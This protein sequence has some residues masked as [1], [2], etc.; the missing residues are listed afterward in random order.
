V[1]AAVEVQGAVKSF[2]LVRAVDGVDLRVFRGEIY[3]LVGPSG[4]GKTTLI[5]M[6]C[7]LLGRDAG[8]V[9]VLGHPIPEGKRHV[10]GRLGYMP[11]E[12]A[13][14]RDL[15]VEENLLFFGQ[16]NGM[17]RGEIRDRIAEILEFMRLSHLAVHLAGNLSGGEKQ[18]LSLAC[19]L[20]S[21]PEL[22]VLD[23]P[24]VGL[25]PALRQEFWEH[26]HELKDEGHTI[27]L[28][29]HYLE[30][31]GRCSR[32]GFMRAGRLQV[33]GL[34]AELQ[35]RVAQAV[36]GTPSMEEVFL[37]FARKGVE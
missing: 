8:E 21:K 26:F 30:E 28:T 10:E 20:L 32:V 2:G 34:P 17:P 29:T 18:R 15:T 13:L 16:L 36:G 27:L 9:R 24:T 12:R 19:A 1:E 23:E 35:A 3:G 25:D 6:I 11:Q 37:F 33:E 22:L 14:Y 5:R 31:A 7:G 4:A